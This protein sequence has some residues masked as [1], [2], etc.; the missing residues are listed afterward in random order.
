MEW[1][2]ASTAT[3]SSSTHS[4]SLKEHLKDVIGIH[5]THTATTS[6]LIN[7]LNICS[8]VIHLSLLWVR[9][10]SIC[11]TNVF[12]LGL[13]FLLLLFRL[14]AVLI[15]VPLNGCH[16][17]GLLD[18]RVSCAF[19]HTQDRVIIL[20]L[21]FL[22][23]NLG[24]AQLFTQ[25][26][27]LRGDILQLAVLMHCFLPELLIHLNVTFLQVRLCVLCIEC[28]CRFTICHSLIIPT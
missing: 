9:E 5:T 11:L 21:T 8:I 13:G 6:T 7:F 22:Y 27:R 26:L 1:E 4:T 16:S 12:K 15:R 17:V 14:L 24:G 10:H 23:F 18:L 3:T 25:T 19:I 20:S 28:D 2:W